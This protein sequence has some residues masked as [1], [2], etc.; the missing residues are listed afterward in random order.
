MT[1]AG[2]GAPQ[3][4]SRRVPLV[5]QQTGCFSHTAS[6]QAVAK[7]SYINWQRWSQFKALNLLPMISQL[8]RNLRTMT[9]LMSKKFLI[10][11]ALVLGTA[12]ASAQTNSTTVTPPV[13]N[14]ATG[15]QTTTIG[16]TPQEA[17]E[18]N[19]KAVPRSDTA[20]V[21]R[22]S[23]NAADA[24][25]NATGTTAV[26]NDGTAPATTT[27]TTTTGDMAKPPVVR[28]ARADRN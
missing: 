20:T 2:F 10:S 27:A 13:S 4:G 22:T 8:N 25:R 24:T 19:R 14:T 21:V 18:A 26:T 5:L 12:A 9:S 15:Q 28:K 6:A 16:V 3:L 11:T 1:E 17:A 23:P 7:Y